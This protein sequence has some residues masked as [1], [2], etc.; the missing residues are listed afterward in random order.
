[1]SPG[2]DELEE[3]AVDAP[4]HVDRLGLFARRDD[5]Q[6]AESMQPEEFGVLA[7]RHATVRRRHRHR[8]GRNWW[9]EQRRELDR[10]QVT[11]TVRAR[12]QFERDLR[13]GG[14]S[15][16][17]DVLLADRFGQQSS[18]PTGLE[19]AGRPRHQFCPHLAKHRTVDG[20][21]NERVVAIEGFRHAVDAGDP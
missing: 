14:T 6:V 18:T 3:R 20:S 8:R 1:V 10:Q 4:E 21:P 15:G 5:G 11:D 16:G 12:V 7:G 19:R 13:S 17:T 2:S 9:C